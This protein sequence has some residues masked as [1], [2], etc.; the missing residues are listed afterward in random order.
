MV[1][2]LLVSFPVRIEG[3]I[4]DMS[5]YDHRLDPRLVSELRW[6]APETRWMV[7]DRPV[8][9]FLVHI[10]VVP[11]LAVTSSTLLYSG[12]QSAQSYL[13]MVDRYHPRLVLLARFRHVRRTLNDPLVQRGYV[14]ALKGR[15]GW[16]YV[17]RDTVGSD[18]KP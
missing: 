16:L 9:P 3:A 13:Q 14:A 7:T 18:T 1:W 11:E 2:L 4:H 17:R 8:Y 12:V 6:L 5:R 15:S 10:N